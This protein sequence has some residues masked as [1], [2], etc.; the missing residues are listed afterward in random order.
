VCFAVFSGS[1]WCGWCKKLEKEVF[2]Q[3]D[4]LKG[5]TNRYTL[6]YVDSPQKKSLLSA[7]AA[8]RNPELVKKYAIE[9]FPTVL[10]LDAQ[11]A[12]LGKTGYRRGGGAA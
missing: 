10:V 5:A 12:V 4:F 8:K 9:G 3:G 2:A 7:T 6:V 1:D 11:G